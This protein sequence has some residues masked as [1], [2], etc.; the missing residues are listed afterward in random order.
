MNGPGR[1]IFLL[2]GGITLLHPHEHPHELTVIY[3]DLPRQ[4]TAPFSAS[5]STSLST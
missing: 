5:A 3:P 1:F 4:I 2:V